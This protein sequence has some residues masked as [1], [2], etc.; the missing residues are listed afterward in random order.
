M[1]QRRD[2]E[3]ELPGADAGLR[4]EI[5][6]DRSATWEFICECNRPDCEARV[7]LSL[8]QYEALRARR[9]RVLAPG[10][11]ETHG[12]RARRIATE[13]RDNAAAL[14]AQAQQQFERAARGRR[15]TR[16]STGR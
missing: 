5:E 13:L 4:Q 3:L 8:P 9:D 2:V 14:R 7:V 12:Q 10:H 15:S 6:P 11:E 16:W 1:A